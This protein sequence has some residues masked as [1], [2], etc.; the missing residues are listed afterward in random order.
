MISLPHTQASADESLRIFGLPPRLGV[1]GTIRGSACPAFE[2]CIGQLLGLTAAVTSCR[3]LDDQ[4]VLSSTAAHDLCMW[5]ISGA[6]ER[7][8]TGHV[9]GPESC[10][11]AA[12]VFNFRCVFW[13]SS[14]L[15]HTGP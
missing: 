3:F 9:Q 2:T 13:C 10:L 8:V 15:A 4:R 1:A 12:C 11:I 5:D 14:V 6:R 7:A